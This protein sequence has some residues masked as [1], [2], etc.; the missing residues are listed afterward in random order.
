MFNY[1]VYEIN[2]LTSNK[3]TKQQIY[4]NKILE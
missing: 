2:L 1:Q 4:L 3:S